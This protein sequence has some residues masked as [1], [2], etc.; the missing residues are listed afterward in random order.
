MLACRIHR[1]VN[2]PRSPRR[3]RRHQAPSIAWQICSVRR[4]GSLFLV[5]ALFFGV[6]AAL[7]KGEAGGT[8]I[9]LGNLSAPWLLLPFFAGRACR[10]LV[11]AA[12]VGG[13]VAV[14]S[15]VGFYA[16]ASAV[17]DMVNSHTIG[18]NVVY[19]VG[20]L[21]SGP[22]FGALGHWSVRRRSLLAPAA[23]GLALVAEPFVQSRDWS[24][25]GMHWAGMSLLQASG[26]RWVRDAPRPYGLRLAWART[27]PGHGR[28]IERSVNARR[29]RLRWL[30]RQE[31]R[32]VG[33]RW[34]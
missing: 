23:L 2:Q 8:R 22:L 16:C 24:I 20:A 26:N 10:S 21:I 34:R 25:N 27:P 33:A 19:F 17:Y 4:S 30:F 12:V 14:F 18:I 7:L 6:A 28:Q 32:R 13:A 3:H 9:I 31:E 15:L 1:P 5:L 11:S 29:A